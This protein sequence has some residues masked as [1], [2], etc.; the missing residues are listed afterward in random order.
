MARKR[1]NGL[2]F[3]VFSRKVSDGRRKF[4]VRFFYDGRLFLTRSTDAPTAAK[5]GIVAKRIMDTE[6]LLAVAKAKAEGETAKLE[7]IDR[8]GQMPVVEFLRLFWDPCR[9]PYLEDLKAAGRPL[10]AHYVYSMQHNIENVFTKASFAQLPMCELKFRHIDALFRELRKTKKRSVLNGLRRTIQKPVYWLAERG[11][12]EKISLAGLVLPKEE[13]KE[14]GILTLD[15]FQRILDIEAVGPWQDEKGLIHVGTRFRDR[16]PG[17]AHY[18][19]LPAVG[20]REKLIIALLGLTGMRLGEARALQWQDVDLEKGLVYIQR[21]YIDGDGLKEPKARSRRTVPLSVALV[22]L[23]LEAR[24]VA[25]QV[26]AAGPGNFVLLN[27]SDQ[28]RPIA[29]STAKKAWDRVLRAIGISAE[30]QK[31]RNLVIHG[32]RH[33]YATRL[34]DAGLTPLE[35]AKMTG[36][37]TLAVLGRYSD[38]VQVETL[39]KG[40][41]AID[42][43]AGKKS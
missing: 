9:S 31:S 37:R 4:Y 33:F 3:T 13:A 10:S 29:E 5:A 7:A 28:S 11:V 43:L 14:R 19:D 38:H 1:Q 30:E 15:E 26:G 22:P 20:W 17:G 12:I 24:K 6:D 23:L 27:A 36:H 34:I 25:Q 21:N 35:A 42:N 41:N 16:L 32:L 40:K 39:Q 18:T 8:Y 2:D